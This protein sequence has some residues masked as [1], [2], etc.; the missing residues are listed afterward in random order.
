MSDASE[1]AFDDAVPGWEC[2]A[3]MVVPWEMHELVGRSVCARSGSEKDGAGEGRESA[4]EQ[5]S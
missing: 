2:S 3:R 4:L 1:E 5:G